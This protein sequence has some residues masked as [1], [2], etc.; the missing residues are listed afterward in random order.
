MASTP[1]LDLLG[2]TLD[3]TVTY[4]AAV[5]PVQASLRTPCPHWDVRALINHSVY[6]L[7]LF[8]TMVTGGERPAPGADLIGEDNWGP[9]FQAAA[10]KLMEAWKRR[11]VD[12]TIKVGPLG[13]V[14]ATWVI[15]QH[16]SDI[17]VHGW[18]IA[19]ATD[20]NTEGDPD[21][22]ETAL[23]WGRAN[24]KPEFRGDAF[25]PEVKP[26]ENAPLY[27]RLANFFGRKS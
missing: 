17:A 23:E 6:D 22:G 20:Q 4:I 1:T 9:V 27:D 21:V 24:L 14:P 8:E 2:R 12:G 19:R 5:K 15:G 26:K 25:G 10:D 7:Q 11:G 3:Q 16:L 13:E 18:D